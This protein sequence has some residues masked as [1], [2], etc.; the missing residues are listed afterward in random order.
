MVG[1]NSIMNIK[2]LRRLLEVAEKATLTPG[3]LTNG[4]KDNHNIE[5]M[6]ASLTGCIPYS[7]N[8][9]ITPAGGKI[10]GIL[11]PDDY[12]SLGLPQV[13]PAKLVFENPNISQL[14]KS[15]F[16]RFQTSSWLTL[17]ALNKDDLIETI[18]Y[19]I[20]YWENRLETCLEIYLNHEN[21]SFQI[22]ILTHL[23]FENFQRKIG[24]E[25][26]IAD[27]LNMKLIREASLDGLS[28][29][30]IAD[31]QYRLCLNSEQIIKLRANPTIDITT[32]LT[33]KQVVLT[34]KIAAQIGH[35]SPSNQSKQR[36]YI[37]E[38]YDALSKHPKSITLNNGIVR[39][40]QLL[41]IPPTL[42]YIDPESV[43]SDMSETVSQ[44]LAAKDQS[45]WFD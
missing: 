27:R 3:L 42:K 35:Y 9:M 20:T 12:N 22:C 19:F 34:A 44:M 45:Y 21:I 32:V 15:Y 13:F 33:R 41:N 8:C 6:L 26:E 18:K 24:G 7:D 43:L 25:T 23:G 39:L 5:G 10:Y 38:L 40:E 28:Y 29:I 30:G 11:P 17:D 36:Y 16:S 14:A 2:T 31:N 37:K 1:F 4:K